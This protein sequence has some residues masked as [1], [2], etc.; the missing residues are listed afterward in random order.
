MSLCVL[1]SAIEAIEPP[2]NI[3]ICQYA[4][5]YGM[6]GTGS[7]I[8]SYSSD[9]TPFWKEV[10]RWLSP[11]DPT[12]QVK[13]IKGT[14]LGGTVLG[15]MATMYYID[16]VPTTQLTL[17]A[18]EDVMTDYANTKIIET[19]NL[20]P[21]VAD[22]IQ[23]GKS[24][25]DIGNTF[26]KKY[27]GGYYKIA[28]GSTTKSYISTSYQFVIVDDVDRFP[29]DIGNEGSPTEMALN[30]IESYGTRGKF[31]VNSTPS[32]KGKSHID[33][34]YEDSDQRRYYMPCPH[35]TPRD[36]SLQNKGNMVTF[37]KDNFHYEVDDYNILSDVLFCCPHCGSMIEEYNKTWM[38]NPANGAKT[39]AENP[40][41]PHKGLRV[42]SYYSPLGMLSWKKIFIKYQSG[43]KNM[44]NG[45]IRKMKTWVNTVDARAWEEEAKSMDTQ[46]EELL[47][48]REEYKAE[49][50]EGVYLLTC[51]V[52]T[53]DTWM[54]AT[55]IGWGKGLESW[56]ITHKKIYG[57]P[58][59][60]E[61]I[62]KL[63]KFLNRDFTHVSGKKMRI[64]STAIDSQG[65]RADAI[66]KYCRPRFN[67]RVYAIKGNGAIDKSG[68]SISSALVK[69]KFSK[70]TK[71]GSR[72]GIVYVNAIKDQIA[73]NITII[74]GDRCMHFP[75]NEEYNEEYFYGLTCEVKE[76]S[77]KWANVTRARNEPVDCA[78]YARAALEFLHNFDIDKLLNPYFYTTV[79]TTG[80]QRKKQR[81]K[82]EVNRS[83]YLDEY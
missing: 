1:L 50:P 45:D 57:D 26:N 56:H 40:S 24:K 53:Q 67:N 9:R 47:E 14:Q 21:K 69:A 20:M 63:D 41:S 60:A 16:V 80:Q 44:K 32:L 76:A 72:L 73:D 18:S 27:K 31:Y 64:Y 81:K 51:G 39:I 6:I 13:V 30:R 34:E 11:Q 35:C 70:N 22:K 10:M 33:I 55:V 65:H 75:K 79:T 74:R 68:T 36:I 7:E 8:G 71:D 46:I 5:K 82:R 59:D 28:T 15:V 19:L 83:N 37:E 61:T 48:R 42:P 23:G 38:M 62:E 78:V 52:D 12:V 4:D 3:D 58:N 25:D 2:E 17:C 66:Y 54:E 49:V 77:G 43:L 29:W